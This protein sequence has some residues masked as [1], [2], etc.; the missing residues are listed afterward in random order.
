[1]YVRTVGLIE[2]AHENRGLGHDFL[3]H[4]EKTKVRKVHHQHYCI[5]SSNLRSTILT[6]IVLRNVLITLQMLLYVVDISG[7]DERSPANDLRNLLYEIKMYDPLL[8][9]RPSLVFAN[10]TDIPS[11]YVGYLDEGIL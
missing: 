4:I 1:M 9:Q 3:K 2:G 11:T 8:L 6:V 5:A 10:K 7:E